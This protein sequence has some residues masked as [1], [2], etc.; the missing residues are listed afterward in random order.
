MLGSLNSVIGRT[1][2]SIEK[3]D[4]KV[5]AKSTA[6]AGSFSEILSEAQNN[7]DTNIDLNPIFQKA[8]KMYD[9]SEELLKAVAKAESDFDTNCVS[10][11]G[12]KGIM[13]LMPET[14][15]GLG[16]TD[17][18]DPEQNI[19]G[20]AKYLSQ[21]LKEF[22]QNVELALA[23]YNAGS[24]SVNKYGGIPPYTETQN[25]VKKIMNYLDSEE[26]RV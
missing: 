9:I 21:K 16:V 18:F 25:Y 3:V 1:Y 4:R 2:M 10:S 19:M 13:Q 11:S 22:D 26:A 20:G 17:C 14:A 12:A 6:K 24:G 7:S 8:A 23:A 5:E 15:K